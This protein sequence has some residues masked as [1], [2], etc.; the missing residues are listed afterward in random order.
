MFSAVLFY[1]LCTAEASCCTSA[2]HS[3][4]YVETLSELVKIFRTK[5]AEPTI[6][7]TNS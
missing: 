3:V 7:P 2:F 1:V 5:Y 4:A 6:G